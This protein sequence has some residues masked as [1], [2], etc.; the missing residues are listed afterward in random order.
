MFRPTSVVCFTA[1][2]GGKVITDVA[3]KYTR[4]LPHHIEQRL[5]SRIWGYRD[6]LLSRKQTSKDNEVF[7][8]ACTGD[9]PKTLLE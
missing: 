2:S 1:L 3:P 8:G 5:K 4:G 6:P 7:V 9:I